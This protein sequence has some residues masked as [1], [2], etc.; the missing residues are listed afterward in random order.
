MNFKYLLVVIPILLNCKGDIEHEINHVLFT[1][2][3]DVYIYEIPTNL[4]E[5]SLNSKQ[6]YYDE[7]N[8]TT[9][10]H[11]IV[12][13]DSGKVFIGDIKKR[14]IHVFSKEGDYITQIGREGKGPGEFLFRVKCFSITLAP[15]ATAATETSI[16]KE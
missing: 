3:D 2:L 10:I 6:V 16:P 9:E 15:S 13:D 11:Q 5:I 14:G 7:E 8:F 4:K 1:D 12:V